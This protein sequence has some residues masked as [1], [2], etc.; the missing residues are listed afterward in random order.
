MRLILRSN[1]EKISN[2]SAGLSTAFIDR[3]IDWLPADITLIEKIRE[4]M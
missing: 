1:K 2:L 4:R 3:T